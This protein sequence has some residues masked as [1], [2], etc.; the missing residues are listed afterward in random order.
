MQNLQFQQQEFST[1]IYLKT[2]EKLHRIKNAY[3]Y[4]PCVEEMV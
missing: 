3:G 4:E 1:F 2:K